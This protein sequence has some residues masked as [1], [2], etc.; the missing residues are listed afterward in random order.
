MDS[1]LRDAFR[2]RDDKLVSLVES[3]EGIDHVERIPIAK[4]AKEIYRLRSTLV[5]G[6]EVKHRGQ[7]RDAADELLDS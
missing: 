1:A 2:R 3:N 4:R 5:H 7:I 6:G